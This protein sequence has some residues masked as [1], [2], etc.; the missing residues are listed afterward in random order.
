[1]CSMQ[2]CDCL[3]AGRV[4]IHLLPRQQRRMERLRRRD[5]VHSVRRALSLP[6]RLHGRLAF[7][8]MPRGG[9]PA[10]RFIP[11]FAAVLRRGGASTAR[12]HWAAGMGAPA[13]RGIH[14]FRA[15]IPQEFGPRAAPA[16]AALVCRSLFH[17]AV[18]RRPLLMGR[19]RGR[20]ET[21]INLACD[22][23]QGGL[24]PRGARP[25]AGRGGGARRAALGRLSG[26]RQL[27][28]AAPAAAEPGGAAPAGGGAG[29]QPR[30][31]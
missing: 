20:T 31:A 30:L 19:V 22:P 25:R 12:A 28:P 15:G 21:K 14:S 18:R 17:C 13:L 16:E 27:L 9:R 8:A 10:V 3:Q 24:P 23:L 6:W 7:V 1:M 11:S 26:D 29:R 5:G 4:R 2:V